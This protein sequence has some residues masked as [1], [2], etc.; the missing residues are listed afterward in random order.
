[1]AVI[2]SCISIRE[3]TG[4]GEGAGGPRRQ[5]VVVRDAGGGGQEGDR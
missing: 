2:K 3:K 4:M 1:M 5:R